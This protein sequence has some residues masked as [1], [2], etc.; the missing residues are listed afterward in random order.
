M[1]PSVQE[2]ANVKGRHKLRGRKSKTN[3]IDGVRGRRR[4]GTANHSI[5]HVDQTIGD[6]CG[7]IFIDDEFERF[8]QSQVGLRNWIKLSAEEYTQVMEAQWEHGIK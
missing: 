6:L 8:L 1:C 3:E 5:T 4:H 2:A 7:A